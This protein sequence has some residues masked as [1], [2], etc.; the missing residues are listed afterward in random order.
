MDLL[1][2]ATLLC[3]AMQKAVLPADIAAL[4][5]VPRAWALSVMLAAWSMA[6]TG[7]AV[8]SVPGAKEFAPAFSMYGELLGAFVRSA[9]GAT[10]EE[11]LAMAGGKFARAVVEIGAFV[12]RR[13]VGSG[14]FQNAE[15]ALLVAY[16]VPAALLPTSAAVTAPSRGAGLS[17]SRRYDAYDYRTR[18]AR[19]ADSSELSPEVLRD[20]LRRSDLDGELRWFYEQRLQALGLP[21][22][23]DKR[24]AQAAWLAMLK[25]PL[26]E[27]LR[28]YF[29][30]NLAGLNGWEE[31]LA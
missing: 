16:P 20:E 26:S 8:P 5:S 11:G 6:R 13:V 31:E 23:A 29:A 4:L 9:L 24:A 19:P 18:S 22:Y 10:S 17:R 3:R 14:E 28:S 15:R 30:A 12:L 7:Q 27:D 21:A 2:A 25:A 1:Q